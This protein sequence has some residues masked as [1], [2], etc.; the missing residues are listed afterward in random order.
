MLMGSPVPEKEL[1][2]ER[3]RFYSFLD[4]L[5]ISVYFQAPDYSIPFANR[6]F[7][8]RFGKLKEAPCYEILHGRKEPCEECPTFR[9]F[10]TKK[11]Q[12][13]EWTS[14]DGRIYRVYESLYPDIDGSPLVLELAV[15]ITERKRAEEKARKLTQF[16]DLVIDSANVWLNVLDEKGNV[17]IWNKAAEAISGYSRDE[18]IGHGKIWEWLYPDEKYRKEVTDKATLIIQGRA[19]DVEDETIIRTKN[20][21]DRVISWYSRNIVDGK[22]VPIG[23][24]ALGRDVTERKRLEEELGRSK[25]F[26]ESAVDNIPDTVFIKDRSFRYTLVNKACY[27]LLGRSRNEFLGKTD[28]DIF[29]KEEADLYRKTDIEVFERGSAVDMPEVSV[30]DVSGSTY[31][32]HVKKAP[33]RDVK[34][35]A[36]HLIGI[37]RDVTER[38][39]MEEKLMALH[40][41]SIQ[42][43]TATSI[44]EIVNHTLN[45]IEF[46]LGFDHAAF[47]T[48]EDGYTR[49]KESR[50]I[51][52]SISEL[53]LDGPGVVVKAA[54][55]KRTL[56]ILDVRKEEAYVDGRPVTTQ[57]EP[58]SILS[59]LAVPVLIEG[60]AVAVLNVESSLLEAFNE[61]DQ[62]LLETLAMHVASALGRMRQVER[63]ERMVEE[64]TRELRESEAKFRGLYDSMMDGILAND[65]SGRI[66]ECNKAFEKMVGYTLEELRRMKW[67][68]FTPKHY[69]ELEEGIIKEEMLKRGRSGY[70]EKEYMRK[71]GSLVPVEVSATVVKGTEGKPDMIWCVIRDITERRRAGERLLRAERLAAVG[72]TA[73]MVGH[74]LR[75]P[76][77]G[78][79]SAAYY[80]KT[81]LASK[82]DGKTK[83]MLKLIEKDVEYSDGIINDLLEYSKEIPLELTETTPKSITKD[84]LSLVKA[85]KKIRIL[86]LTKKEPRIKV[87]AQK[88]GRVF[89]NIVKNA[90]EAMPEGGK[91]TITSKRSN[92]NLEIVFTD[93]G[94]GITKEAMEKIF[95]PLFTTKAKGIGLGLP[96]SKRIVEAHGGSIS[97]K[98]KTGKGATFTVKLPIEPGIEG[99]EKA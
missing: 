11:P 37:T 42:L 8:E 31:I 26:L 36:T 47:S 41:H 85:P 56:R 58:Q 94:T 72:E 1:E 68:D 55:T 53:P 17:V 12:E 82:M 87:D 75:N 81:K 65:V 14:G 70:V 48:V 60:E 57:G 88:I 10:E 45:A 59:E 77:T 97:V 84:A 21:E 3:R 13:W 49:V 7:Q 69:L 38:R 52:M 24:V 19:T 95:S 18:V 33:L 96:I 5:P 15:D 91:L 44:D 35:N 89:V 54:K 71:D 4:R 23:S 93:T 62:M 43:N 50:G 64:R 32:H 34:G 30:T 79:A 61:A 39:R 22:G 66:F 80:L 29:P 6:Y 73:A 63:L 27:E 16:L 2:A 90:V 98:S 51:P 92:G 76:L 78:I 9:V 40:S 20:G 83:E 86:D 25:Q 74:D 28:Y 99:G 46:T 67:Q